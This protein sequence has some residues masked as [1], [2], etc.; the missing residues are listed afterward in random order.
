MKV[1]VEKIIDNRTFRG[2]VT[3]YK[4]H[5]KYEKYLTSYKSY[6]IHFE[7]EDLKIGQEV[8]VVQSRP[9]SKRKRWKLIKEGV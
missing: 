6:L 3:S 9:I 2:T 7:G 1:K 8:S 5:T 4:K